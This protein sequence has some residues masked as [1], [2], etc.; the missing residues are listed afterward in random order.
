MDA[1]NHVTE[2]TTS[3]VRNPYSML[4]VIET[5]RLVKECL[6]VSVKEPA[7]LGAR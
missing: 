7:N 3:G 1:L 4:L 5:V 2:A 6:P